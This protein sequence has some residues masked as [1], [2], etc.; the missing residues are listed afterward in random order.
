MALNKKVYGAIDPGKTGYI[1]LLDF[2]GKIVWHGHTPVVGKEYDKPSMNNIIAQFA[3]CDT[4]CHFVLENV[5]ATQMGGKSSN[6]DFGR[7]KGLWEMALIANNIPHTMVNPKQW[8]K[9]VWQGIKKQYKPTRRKT[10]AGTFVKK[11]DTKATSLL[12]A[13]NLMPDEDWRNI[14]DKTAKPVS[15]INDGKVDAYLMAEYC[16][17]NFK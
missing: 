14:S 8:Q 2:Q 5:H 15:S 9:C 12:A 11:I 16:R 17:R 3:D 4:L 10:K 6:F 1:V 13:K 7:G